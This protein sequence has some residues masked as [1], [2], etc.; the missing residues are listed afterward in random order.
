[1]TALRG[2]SAR[3]WATLPLA[4]ALVFAS[5]LTGPVPDGRA[6][7]RAPEATPGATGTAAPLH[8]LPQSQAT[9]KLVPLYRKTVKVTLKGGRTVFGRLV[10]IRLRYIELHTAAGQKLR[11]PRSRLVSA[12]RAKLPS[13]GVTADELRR[14]QGQR[15]RLTK[16]SGETLEG[17]IRAVGE[18]AV[19]LDTPRGVVEV[20]IDTL[21]AVQRAS[22]RP[23]PRTTAEKLNAVVGRPVRIYRNDGTRLQGTLK[24]A[25]SEQITVQTDVGDITVRITDIKRF[26]VGSYRRPSSASA[27]EDTAGAA[28]AAGAAGRSRAGRGSGPLHRRGRASG[29]HGAGGL[30]PAAAA[31]RDRLLKKYTRIK[32]NGAKLRNWGIGLMVTSAVLQ[33]IGTAVALSSA[34]EPA[35]LS[36]AAIGGVGGAMFVPGLVMMIWGQVRHIRAIEWH[37]RVRMWD[38][39]LRA[40]AP[41]LGAGN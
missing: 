15:V 10:N 4:A 28:G 11:L 34:S 29:G 16:R 40:G 37:H 21:K 3:L 27:S 36:G 12:T 38:Q 32:K 8:S 2:A 14:H 24:Q 41:G 33:A 30:S 13:A 17:L 1:V 25:D 18:R 31:L 39:G 26:L 5:A 23:R 9:Q 35:V 6:E 20:R 7:V 19:N 22:A